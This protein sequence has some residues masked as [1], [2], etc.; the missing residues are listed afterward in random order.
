MEPFGDVTGDGIEELSV[1]GSEEG[2]D[3]KTKT[4]VRILD[5]AGGEVV[6]SFAGGWPARIG[7]LD[8]D[9]RSEIL[10]Q[11]IVSW[12]PEVAIRYRLVNVEGEVG[13]GFGALRRVLLPAT[14]P[15][16]TM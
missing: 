15:E 4:V 1:R 5:G 3:G 13:A 10:H 9:G 7:D 16:P 11:S 14:R 2:E 12:D 8:E 6:T